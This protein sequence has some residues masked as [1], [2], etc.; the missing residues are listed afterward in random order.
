MCTKC[1]IIVKF[2]GKSPHSPSKKQ[3]QFTGKFHTELNF[4][5]VIDKISCYI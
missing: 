4:V 3:Q 2:L 1:E 5:F